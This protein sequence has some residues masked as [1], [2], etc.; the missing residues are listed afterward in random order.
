MTTPKQRIQALLCTIDTMEAG[1]ALAIV[2][3][4]P[5]DDARFDMQFAGGNA[6]IGFW[7]RQPEGETG[8]PTGTPLAWALGFSRRCGN[9]GLHVGA[10]VA[11]HL[12]A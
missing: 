1:E 3:D 4:L 2:R 7:L 12:H 11:M 10:C 5:E 8:E 6:A 9:Q